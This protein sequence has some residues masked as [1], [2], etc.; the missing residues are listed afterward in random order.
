MP[1]P[2]DPDAN[3]WLDAQAG[4]VVRP[5]AMTAGRTEPE[6]G[7][8]DL[9]SSVI[10]T[11][12]AH[13]L[14]VVDV[15]EHTSIVKLCQGPMSV[16]EVSAHLQLPL[17]T[18][19]VLLGDLLDRGLLRLCDQQPMTGLPDDELCQEVIDGLRAL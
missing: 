10:A 15:P 14:G 6:R 17:G 19:R 4:P 16:A 7:R 1:A 3:L 9:I 2:Y 5:Y 13:A 8:L 11:R 18:A 12:P